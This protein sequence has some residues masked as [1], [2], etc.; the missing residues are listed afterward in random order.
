VHSGRPAAGG[1]LGLRLA[2]ELA[3]AALAE[4]RSAPGPSTVVSL[5]EGAA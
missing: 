5:V 4:L 3:A 1:Y 2:H